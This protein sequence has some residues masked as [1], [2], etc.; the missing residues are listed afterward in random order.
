MRGLCLDAVGGV[1]NASL[2]Q[3]C[4]RSGRPLQRDG[5]RLFA[6]L[7]TYLGTMQGK[8]VFN[9]TGQYA[10]SIDGDRVV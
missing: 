7:G 2:S 4:I 9:T 3:L 5:D 1:E 8:Y 10:E 6:G